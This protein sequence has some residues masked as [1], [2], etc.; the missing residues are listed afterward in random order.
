MERRLTAILSYDAVGYSLAMGRDE[1]G[2]LDALKSDRRRII[3]PKADQH[4]GRII[5]LMGDGALLEFA[6]VVDAVTF[7]V[8]MQCALT[9]RNAKLPEEQ[10]R[11]YRIGINV[12]DVIIDGE[13]IYGDGVNVA[14]RLE[15]LAEPGGI[16]IH[17]S[18]RDQLRGKL[19]LDFDDLGEVEVKNIERPVR[20]FRVTLNE[21]ATAIAARPDQR[22]PKPKR[23]ARIWQA[24]VGVSLALALTV[25]VVWWQSRAPEFEP[26]DPAEMAAALPDKPSMAV[27][28][29]DDLSTGED[30][31]YLSD[32]IAEGIT[33][34]LSRFSEFLVIARNSS[35]KYRD[36][37]TDVRTI[38]KELGVHYIVEGS[39]QKSGDQ[40]RVTV[41][42]IDALAGNHIWADTYDR[43]L[44]DL[45]AVQ[46]EIVR[47]ITAA[48]GAK[49]AFRAPPS[50]GLAAVSA[51][52]LNLL[53]R[54][55]VR[56][57]SR[58]GTLK[59]LELNL[60]A[61][62]ADPKAP[63]GYIGL[64]F[65]YPRAEYG[66]LEMD[67][68]TGLAK[69]E[70]AADRALALD[71]DNYDTH[72]ARAFVHMQRGEQDRAIERYRKALEL[73]PNAAN[74]MAALAGPMMYTG[75][76]DEALDL[77]QEAVR[78]DPHHPDWFKWNLA[79][80]QWGKGDCH[81][82]L[83]TMNAMTEMPNRARRMLAVVQVCLGR[84]AEAEATVAKFLEKDPGDTVTAFREAA[85]KRYTDKALLD[86]F[87]DG[88]RQAGL[89]E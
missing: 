38:A 9:D 16:C 73:N 76:V 71:P 69:A 83:A 12:G 50:G 5:K 47:A 31:G 44:A 45:F 62:E 75:H 51:L 18:V 26:V 30:Q 7:A 43:D 74:V 42:L 55:F 25:G 27:L 28:A 60:A 17:Q 2:T 87:A 39:Q 54:P 80:A 78:L 13:D 4:G 14:S 89:P 72:F 52:H 79:W 23:P 58:E 82:A 46:D 34:E 68:P 15:G 41:Q 22:T 8:A 59:A 21:K 86:R 24:A 37:A 40:L 81:S 85:D 56:Q 48:I 63:Y 88:L 11:L 84:Q 29:L 61:V 10:R 3:D 20:A 19:D 67:G 64:A 33:T 32:A 6:S 1:A 65:L 49:V 36:T 77:M 66:W 70:E 57:W 53:G 35:F